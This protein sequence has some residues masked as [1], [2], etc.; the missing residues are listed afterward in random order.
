[1]LDTGSSSCIAPCDC[2]CATLWLWRTVQTVDLNFS[3]GGPDLV[4]TAWQL[5]T[6]RPSPGSAVFLGASRGPA[7]DSYSGW[8]WIDGTT[9]S[10]N[11]QCSALGCSLFGPSEPQ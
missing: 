5:V 10:S 8:T 3:G 4:S 7:P 11:L 2:M 6:N 1:M 9:P